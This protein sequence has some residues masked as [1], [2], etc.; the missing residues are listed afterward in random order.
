LTTVLVV[1]AVALLSVAL[2]IDR[3]PYLS[4][5]VR[6]ARAAV[7]VGEAVIQARIQTAFMA[8][9]K[10]LLLAAAAGG[11]RWVWLQSRLVYPRHALYPQIVPGRSGLLPAAPANVPQAQV[12]AALVNGNV[13]RLNGSTAKQA[14]R[15]P[16]DVPL[17]EEPQPLLLPERVMVYDAP[18]DG[19]QLVLP[20]GVSESGPLAFPLRNLGNGVIGGLQGGGKSELL[21]AMMAGLLRQDPDGRRLRIALIDMKGGA[22]FGQL[23]DD[24]ATLRWPVAR[25]PETAHALLAAL[26]A[27]I[28]R[29]DALFRQSGA[30]NIEGY[31]SLPGIEPLPY[32]L[33][34]ADEIMFLTRPATDSAMSAER[35]AQAKSFI[36]TAI[37]IV[38]IGRNTG[39]SLILATQKP[40]SDVI[41]TTLRDLCGWKVAFSCATTAAYIAVLGQSVD[42]RLPDKPGRCYVLRGRAPQV[43]QSYMAGIESG[44]FN[45]YMSTLPRGEPGRLE[46]VGVGAE[47][48]VLEPELELVGVATNQLRLERGRKPSPE[49]AAEIRRLYSS[50][51][52]K[53]ALCFRVWNYKDGTVWGYVEDA[54]EGRL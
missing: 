49:Q 10:L 12:V 20:I 15:P 41:P 40:S 43:A 23:P 53:T 42:D 47:E 28:Q 6:A 34:F 26:F 52:P 1:L 17:L 16:D 22:D 13:D 8:G 2:V 37:D 30:A 21:A 5:D 29:R 46:L 44:Q 14:L 35:R 31:N 7:A 51:M 25:D 39:V 45:R 19:R 36:S 27:E 32:L 38:S 4:P 3:L 48:P 18:L 50:G 11:V 24:L 54:I 33:T 9:L